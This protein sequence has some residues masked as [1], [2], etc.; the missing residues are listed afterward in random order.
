MCQCFESFFVLLLRSSFFLFS[1][2]TVL[3]VKGSE[4]QYLD[5]N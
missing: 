2:F 4:R 5:I 1:Q 3:D